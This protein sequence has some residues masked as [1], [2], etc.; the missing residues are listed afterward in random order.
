[1]TEL[2]KYGVLLT[3][4]KALKF[5]VYAQDGLKYAAPTFAVGD[6]K[7]SKNGGAY[8]NTTNLPVAIGSSWYLILTAAELTASSINILISDATA[9]QVWLD[10]EINVATHGNASAMY[11]IDLDVV[12]RGTDGANTTT[13]NIIIPQKNVAFANIPVLMV[14][15]TD[16][17]TPKTGLTLTVT[18][19]I[20]GGAFG[21]ATGTAAEISAGMYQFD[22]SAA[23][24][25]GDVITFRFTGTAA[26]DSFITVHTKP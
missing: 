14:D 22:A 8:A 15:S 12:M 5:V 26:D 11:A 16:H 1:M 18:R 6:V 4:A 9:T 3:A 13:P 25:N 20:N 7:I 21:A 23:D 2:R 24:M 19:S 17:V 10:T